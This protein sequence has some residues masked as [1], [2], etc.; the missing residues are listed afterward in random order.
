MNGRERYLI[1][2]LVGAVLLIPHLG[3]NSYFSFV[4]YLKKWC[5]CRQ[6]VQASSRYNDSS[7]LTQLSDFRVSLINLE[8]QFVYECDNMCIVK[9]GMIKQNES[10]FANIDLEIEPN[11]RNKCFCFL[12]F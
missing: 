7:F 5:A 9:C 8:Q 2:L 11:K 1:T 10:E 4:Q 6:T 3:T 12:L